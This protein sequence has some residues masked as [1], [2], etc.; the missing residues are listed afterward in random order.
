M[1]ARLSHALDGAAAAGRML[2]CDAAVNSLLLLAPQPR[3]ELIEKL[4]VPV[5]QG[6]LLP[7]PRPQ[8]PCHL[9]S[10]AAGQLGNAL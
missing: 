7:R 4:K 5:H 8:S 9:P 1:S 3:G 2:M 10:Q 6:V